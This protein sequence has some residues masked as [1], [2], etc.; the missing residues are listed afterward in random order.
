MG[1]FLGGFGGHE[2][3]LGDNKE[4]II[5]PVVSFAT[6]GFSSIIGLIVGI[7]YITK[8]DQEFVDT[9]VNNKKG[10]F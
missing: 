8:S 5:Q 7:I 2:F 9:H 3:V 4:G 1:I 10:W 6:C